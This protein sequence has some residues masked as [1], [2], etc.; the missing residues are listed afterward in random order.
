MPALLGPAAGTHPLLSFSRMERNG[1]HLAGL[2]GVAP[3]GSAWR[4]TAAAACLSE[5]EEQQRQ[6]HA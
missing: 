1:F 5:E 3:V 2:L 4:G 6:Q